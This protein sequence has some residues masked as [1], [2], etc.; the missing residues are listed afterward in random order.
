MKP[1]ENLTQ[2]HVA[3]KKMLNIMQKIANE[4]KLKQNINIEQIEKIVEFIK[5]FA[6]KNHH[7]KE[8]N[9]LF[10]ALIKAG[11]S[12]ESGPVSVM[13]CEHEEGRK[14]I[15][16]ITAALEVYKSNKQSGLNA[17]VENMENYLNLLHSHIYK[18]DNILFPMSEKILNDVQQE[19]IFTKFMQVEEEVLGNGVNEKYHEL[20]NNLKNIYLV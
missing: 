16:S 11:M 20:L 15:K 4:L 5:I 18:E 17:V 12:K 19:E 14:F 13:L 6:D 3:I 8:E 2:D 10:P 7:G 1:T 9:I